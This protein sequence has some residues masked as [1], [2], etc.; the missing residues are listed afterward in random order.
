[1]KP[2]ANSACGGLMIF[3]SR[4]YAACHQSS[5]GAE[6]SMATAP[7]MQSQPPS[8]PLNRRHTVTPSTGFATEKN[9]RR[10]TSKPHANP[11]TAPPV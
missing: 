3:T 5:N 2:S 7:Q 11:A 6:V 9:E 8:G 1:M 4:P 10:S